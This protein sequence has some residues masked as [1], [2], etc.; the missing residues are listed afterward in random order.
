M[1]QQSAEN[2]GGYYAIKGFEFQI[3]KTIQEILNLD[4]I[5]AVINIEKIQDLDSSDFV[6]QV[7]YRETKDYTDIEVREPVIQL[8]EEFI[9][10]P[11]KQYKLYC[12]FNNKEEISEVLEISR[13]NSILTLSTGTSK[14]AQRINEKIKSFDGTTKNNF[15]E[16]F[17]II[18]APE[19][20]IQLEKI[21]SK[22]TEE[23][24]ISLDDAVFHHG[25]LSDYLRRKALAD[26]TCSKKELLGY[27]QR[28]RTFIFT[29]SFREY[30]GDVAYFR[31][32]KNKHFSPQNENN[33]E[34]F[35]IIELSGK[36]SISDLKH[37]IEAIKKRFYI[38]SGLPLRKVIKSGAPYIY[39][40]NITRETLKQLKTELSQEGYCFKDGHD[41]LDS[42]FCIESLKECSTVSNNICIKFINTEEGF[43]SLLDEKLGKTKEVYHFFTDTP[44]D[45]Q[46]DVKTVKIQINDLSDIS[47]I[48]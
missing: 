17:E 25:N 15:I 27:V 2:R 19:Y 38:K 1:T 14:K 28:G 44:V 20:E 13:L 45:L 41:F 34:R 21:L 26:K 42:E 9:E 37:E 46:Q 10:H 24:K 30:N 11:E 12:H 18:F 48:I 7:K 8:M 31:Y 23:L 33:Y 4:D 32:V 35:F 43:N 16:H 22:M 40:Q 5:E 3:D 39:F 47:L 6:M 29:S 36:E